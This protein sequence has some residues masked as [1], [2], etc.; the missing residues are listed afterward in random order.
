MHGVEVVDQVA[1]GRAGAVEQRLIEV[2]QRDAVPF[3]AGGQLPFLPGQR[4]TDATS[5]ETNHRARSDIPLR[6]RSSFTDKM[7]WIWSRFSSNPRISALM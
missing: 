1:L 5:G 7:W 2:R 4:S 6:P 3:L